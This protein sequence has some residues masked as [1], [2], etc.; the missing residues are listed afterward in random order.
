MI[1][2]AVAILI[3]TIATS[4]AVANL[5]ERIDYWRNN[6]E[7]LTGA[8][9]PRVDR[10]HEIFKRIVDAAGKQPGVVPRLFIAKR[11]PLNVSLPIAIP[12]GWV[13]LSKGTLDICYRDP[14]LGDDRLAFVLAHEFAHQLKGDFWHMQF[15][16][17]LEASKMDTTQQRRSL[18]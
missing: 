5:K 13:I 4:T 6:Y 15:F 14:G 18:E 10:A 7:E 3:V 11:D 8:D 2:G 9:D 1:G 16:Q 17:A 12:D